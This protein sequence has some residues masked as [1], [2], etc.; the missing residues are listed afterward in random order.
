MVQIVTVLSAT[1]RSLMNVLA[2]AEKKRAE[3]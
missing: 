3:G 2:A 1:P